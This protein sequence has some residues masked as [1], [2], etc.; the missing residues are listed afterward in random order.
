MSS[1]ADGSGFPWRS[2]QPAIKVHYGTG[3][4][5]Q[6]GHRVRKPR[7]HQAEDLKEKPLCRMHLVI[8]ENL[9]TILITEKAIL[10]AQD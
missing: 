8:Q 2:E 6:T 3:T 1:E 7:A 5:L 9:C 4:V 10:C